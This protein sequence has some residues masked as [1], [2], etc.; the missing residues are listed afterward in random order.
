MY[1][2]FIYVYNMYAI[3]MICI[4]DMYVFIICMLY[5]YCMSLRWLHYVFAM[6]RPKKQTCS[7]APATNCTRTNLRTTSIW[8]NLGMDTSLAYSPKMI[9]YAEY[10]VTS[11]FTMV[12]LTFQ[13]ALP[14]SY[15]R[16]SAPHGAALCNQGAIF[17]ITSRREC[18]IAPSPSRDLHFPGRFMQILCSFKCHFTNECEFLWKCSKCSI[19]PD[20]MIYHGLSLFFII[21]KMAPCKSM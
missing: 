4:Y 15:G 18:V 6:T 10:H 11:R 8:T 19:P 2:I 9:R 13:T 5:V 14:G 21:T 7:K 16:V 3:F 20:P 17:L 12:H 1:A